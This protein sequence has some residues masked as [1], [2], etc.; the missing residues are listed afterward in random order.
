[1]RDTVLPGARVTEDA[2]SPCNA[3]ERWMQPEWW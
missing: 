2:M 1:M 3:R